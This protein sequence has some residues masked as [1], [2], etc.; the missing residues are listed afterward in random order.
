MPAAINPVPRQ[1]MG[2]GWRV[3][4]GLARCVRTRAMIATGTLIQ[5]IE[6]HVHSV[7]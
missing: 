5:K 2:A 7:R 6:R 4:S 3:S 1:S